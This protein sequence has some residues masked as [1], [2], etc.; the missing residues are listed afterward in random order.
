MTSDLIIIGS[1][2]GG[3]RA[4][5]HAARHG[6]NVTIFERAEA[7]GT[8]LNC[9]CIP[10]K[11]LCRNAE[12]LLTLREAEVYGLRDLHY[13]VDFAAVME[14]KQKVVEQLRSG[15]ETLMGLP[16]I[17]F[18]RGEARFEDERTIV[19]GD[20]R[21]TASDIIIA[22]GS[23]AKMPPIVGI[24]Q[25]HVVTSTELLSIDHL[26]QR[27]CI[28]GAG[29]I[30]MEFAS[31]FNALGSEVTV[32]E[33]LKECLP[34]FD[35]DIA[36]RLRQ[37]LSK[38][39][40][41]FFM[42]SGVKE[43]T[44]T[45][46][47]FERK[48]KESRVAADVVLVATGRAPRVD[49]LCLENAGIATER[50]AIVVDDD[51]QTNV[52]HVFAIGDVNGR[53]MLAHAATCQGL[54]V[55]NRLL[56]IEDHFDLKTIPAAVFTHP[57]AGCVGVTEEQCKDAGM[58]YVCKKGYYR[59]NGKALAMNEGEGLVKMIASTDGHILGCHVLGAHAADMVQEISCL[60]AKGCTVSELRDM[61]HI[62]PTLG[63]MLQEVAAAF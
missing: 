63:E 3:Y 5:E 35:G 34:P 4:A 16:G 39:G 49:G 43:I 59:A 45:E 51:M 18:V 33:F 2:P 47:V 50:G 60:M 19:C 27:L 58:D 41:E 28:I 6:L 12:V 15:V 53:C 21:Y 46:V 10:T 42:Q 62:H 23:D 22:T 55:V 8:C 48:G 13:D 37:Q 14:R 26:P 24:D 25:K 30:G 7:G 11:A 57:E 1:G 61:V 54:H 40:V 56:G 9:G 38:R 31:I 32:V 36:K 20:E 44:P 29:V 52:P 17:T